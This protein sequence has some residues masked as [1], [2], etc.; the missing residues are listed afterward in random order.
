M[1]GYAIRVERGIRR[2]VQSRH[3]QSRE[4]GGRLPL[5]V[6]SAEGM[7]FGRR[8]G[9]GEER[10]GFVSKYGYDLPN[11]RGREDRRICKKALDKQ[12]I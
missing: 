2:L 6:P 10:C 8:S 5:R 12:A 3:R 9:L 11:R 1:R 7:L 4:I